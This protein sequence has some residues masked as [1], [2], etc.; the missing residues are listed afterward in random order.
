[1][2]LIAESGEMAPSVGNN[3]QNEGD[4]RKSKKHKTV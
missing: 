3:A 2:M 4:G 1:M